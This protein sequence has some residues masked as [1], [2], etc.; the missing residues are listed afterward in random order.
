MVRDNNPTLI[1]LGKTHTSFA[2]PLTGS[3]LQLGGRTD[4][5]SNGFSNND[6]GLRLMMAIFFIFT[7]ISMLNVLI[8]LIGHAFDDGDRT[9]ELEWLQN[10]KRYVESAENMTYNVRDLRV[11]HDY[12]PET[13]YY[14][15]GSQS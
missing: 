6:V 15:A 7:D 1:M 9:W 8:A 5:V 4:L 12:F 3:I 14:T 13:T 10:R 2:F 11:A